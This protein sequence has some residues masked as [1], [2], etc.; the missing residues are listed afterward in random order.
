MYAHFDNLDESLSRDSAEEVE[1]QATKKIIS[2][3]FSVKVNPSVKSSIYGLRIIK[4]LELN[5]VN[6]QLYFVT[7]LKFDHC[8]EFF[9][10]CQFKNSQLAQNIFR[11][12]T[13]AL[14]FTKDHHA[15]LD[16][17]ALGKFRK[18]YLTSN[19]GFASNAL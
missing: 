18:T 14:V 15:K 3:N 1:T 4:V 19:D 5:P 10:I 17:N 9:G 12:F 7:I 11:I 6:P 2:K 16:Y 8:G 13:C